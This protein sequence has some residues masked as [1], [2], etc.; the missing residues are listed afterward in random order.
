MYVT[1]GPRQAS[2]TPA[3][4]GPINRAVVMAAELSVTA[5]RRLESG[6]RLESR[7]CRAGKRMEL[8]VPRTATETKRCHTSSASS[9]TKTAMTACV[10]VLALSAAKSTRRRSARSASSPPTRLNKSRGTP[11]TAPSTPSRRMEPVSSY[12]SQLWVMEDIQ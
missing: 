4:A 12:R 9:A 8:A 11:R 7:A 2:S 1:S 3:I 10:S 5:L 6:T